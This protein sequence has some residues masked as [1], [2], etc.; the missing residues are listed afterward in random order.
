MSTAWAGIT[1]T[2]RLTITEISFLSSMI[3]MD[4]VRII[5]SLP[6]NPKVMQL[7]REWK[8]TPDEALGGMVRWLCWLDKYTTD[9]KTG[10]KQGELDKLIFSGK[11]KMSGLI[12]L[13]WAEPDRDGNINSVKFDIFNG[14]TAK[15]RAIDTM[16]KRRQRAAK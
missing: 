6:D 3:D 2:A 4:A 8:S 7:A 9:G 11:E 12:K 5:N 14:P 1:W 15:R 13:G 16:K 10:L